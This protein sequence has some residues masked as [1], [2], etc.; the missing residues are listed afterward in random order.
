[1]TAQ[2]GRPVQVDNAGVGGET[3][4]TTVLRLKAALKTLKPDLV[5]WQVGTNDAVV[6]E[7]EN[8]FRDSLLEGVSA[9]R[10][11]KTPFVLLDPQSIPVSRTS[12]DT[13]NM[14]ASSTISA[15]ATGRYLP[16]TT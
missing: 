3:V 8:S 16:A 7:D 15:N 2:L 11:A 10:A 14:C 13:S 1:M 5:I 4:A 12:L 9:I 6:G